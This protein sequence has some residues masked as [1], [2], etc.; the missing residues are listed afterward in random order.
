MSERMLQKD[1]TLRYTLGVVYAP[2]ELDTDGEYTDEEEIRKA[3]W[4]FIGNLTQIALE[5]TAQESELVKSVLQAAEEGGEIVVEV[6]DEED[7]EKQLGDNHVKF[8]PSFGKI[9]DSFWTPC[10][11]EINGEQVKKGSW[12]L[13]IVWSEEMFEKIRSGERRGYSMGGLAQRR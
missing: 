1:E 3:A 12:L 4:D 13:G 7:V 9:V 2:G 11:M 10:D 5:K 8:D 6:D